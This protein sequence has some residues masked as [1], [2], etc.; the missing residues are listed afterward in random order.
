[1]VRNSKRPIPSREISIGA[2]YDAMHFLSMLS[3]VTNLL[4]CFHTTSYGR[5]LL[6]LGTSESYLLVIFIEQMMLALRS[7]YVSGTSKVPE[8]IMQARA[9]NEYQRNLA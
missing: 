4:I 2:W 9:K 5:S 3:Y 8:E 7:A 6:N 1:M